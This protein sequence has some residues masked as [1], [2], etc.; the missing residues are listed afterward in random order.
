VNH[1]SVF[2]QNIL[3]LLVGL[4]LLLLIEGGLWLVG[5][6]ALADEDRFVGFAG[7]RPLFVPEQTVGTETVFSLNPAKEEY[8]NRQSFAMPKPAPQF[9]FAALGGSTTYGRPYLGDTAFAEWLALLG[10][11][12]EGRFRY[13]AINAGGISYASYR[14]ARLQRELL[15]YDPDLFVVYSGHN[16]FLE[17]RTF[18]E[19]KN[20]THWVKNIRQVAHRS[21]IYSLLT[22][23][24]GSVSGTHTQT[25][26]PDEV[27]VE[28]ETVAGP[29]Y[30][31]R[32]DYF[33]QGVIAQY[34]ASLQAMINR[35]MQ[36]GIPL[37][38]CTLPSNLSAVSPFK[39]EHRPGLSSEQL[40]DWHHWFADGS[41]ALQENMA[42]EAVSAFQ[43]A[44]QIDD[45]YA[46]LHYRLGHALLQNGQPEQAYQAF[47]RAK[48]EDIIPLRALEEFNTIVRELAADNAVPLADVEGMFRRVAANGIPGSDLF[49][50]HVHPNVRGQ[51]MIAWVIFD[52]LV[53]EQIIPL[54]IGRWQRQVGDARKLLLKQ[55][56]AISPHYRALGLWGVGRLYFW[57]GKYAEAYEPL[58][59]AWTE[60]KNVAEIP[61]KLGTLEVF[62]GDGAAAIPLLQEA[63]RL[64]PEYHDAVVMLANA[65]LLEEQADAALAQLQK[66]PA[67]RE[68]SSGYLSA[69][70]RAL[71]MRGEKVAGLNALERA[72]ELAPEAPRPL[73]E[74][75][76]ALAISGRIEMAKAVFARYLQNIQAP[77]PEHALR[78][79]VEQRGW[80]T[81]R[82]WLS[83]ELG[84]Q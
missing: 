33:R 50:D 57:A 41:K 29:D 16:E 27:S 74:Y 47:V 84:T 66:L 42:E 71:V 39:S 69:Q 32:D 40:A 83:T 53:K 22:R 56:N 2:R 6:G 28:L 26:L 17:A 55:E 78:K 43:Q 72:V 54:Q 13:K 73:R 12:F 21:R 25:L 35:A 82:Q 19:I 76:E 77:D 31:H 62:R 30:Y 68:N 9:R 24:I 64:E 15:E 34:R 75:A 3:A 60:L 38:L 46:L 7:S 52:T 49:D 10:N 11:R 45:R 65:Y 36:N 59:Q 67:G 80:L 61:F 18:A 81:S 44:L 14:A 1:L 4:L 70:G 8:F 20:E 58:R 79:W 23:A 37:V 63:F 51:Q 5:V 48:Q